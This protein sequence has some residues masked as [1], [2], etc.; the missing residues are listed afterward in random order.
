[1]SIVGLL[2]LPH[3]HNGEVVGAGDVA[4]SFKSHEPGVLA[5][6]GGELLQKLGRIGRE[7]R[8][9][10]DIGHYVKLGFGLLLRQ[11]YAYKGESGQ[12][13]QGYTFHRLQHTAK[14]AKAVWACA[15]GEAPDS[16]G[17]H[18]V[19][20]LRQAEVTP[21][22]IRFAM[23]MAISAIAV[24]AG[25]KDRIW[26][27]GNLLDTRSNK[28]FPRAE[29]V[30]EDD[31]IL[32]SRAFADSQ[33]VPTSNTVYDHYVVES[34]DAAYLVERGRFKSAKPAQLRPN[35]TVKFAVEKKK[36]WLVDEE[37]KQQEATILKQVYKQTQHPTVTASLPAQ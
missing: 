26:Q 37:G 34:E 3:F 31:R 19:L 14:N 9:H 35:R 33:S 6:V 7:V 10:V 22:K 27:D 28:Y 23:L 13:Q 4:E 11:N 15:L 18:A 5:I 21:M 16:L 8:I 24:S 32:T 20:F 29:P 36:I 17:S 30:G 12:K 1:M 2:A 25:G